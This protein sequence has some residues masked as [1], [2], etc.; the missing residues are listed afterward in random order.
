MN[1]FGYIFIVIGLGADFIGML[2]L[3]RMPD[4]YT[5]MQAAVKTITLGTCAIILGVLFSYG[6]SEV[7]FKALL[8]IALIG[9]TAPVSAHALARGAHKSGIP[10]STESVCDHYHHS[11][12]PSGEEKGNA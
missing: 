5:R 12:V 11:I 7:G 9:L 2:S 1:E 8:C 6:I 4:V 3:L 10:L